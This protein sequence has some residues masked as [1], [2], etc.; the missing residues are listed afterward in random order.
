MAESLFLGPNRHL[1]LLLVNNKVLLIGASEHGIHLLH[2]FNDPDFYTELEQ[3]AGNQQLLPAG[4]FPDL[5]GAVLGGLHPRKV[6]DTDS[7]DTKQRLM[8]GLEKIRSWK[9]RGRNQ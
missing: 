2:D 9:T 4:K 5:I 3:H 8:E 1:Y 6:S 7:F